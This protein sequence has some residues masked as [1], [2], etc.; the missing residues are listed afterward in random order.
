M[1]QRFMTAQ[2][3]HLLMVNFQVDP[4]LLQPL[5]PDGTELDFHDGRT[6]V[7]LVGFEFRDA[8][9]IGLSI[10]FHRNFD[11]INLRFY[12]RRS[13]P[14]GWRRGVVFVKEIV[15]V[16]AVATVARWVY[17]EN[18]VVRPVRHQLRLPAADCPGVIV[19]SFRQNRRWNSLSA[20]FGCELSHP[21]PESEEAFVAEHYWGYTRRGD[22]S[23]AEYH[24]TH[25]PWRIWLAK[26]IQFDFDFAET[27][28]LPFKSVFD[29]APTSAFVAD[30]SAVEVFSATKLNRQA[31]VDALGVRNT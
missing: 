27:Y 19:Y 23:T 6:F 15:R 14:T 20:N 29:S 12:V 31:T 2:W 7:S 26:N 21:L 4:D 1:P 22:G 3:R 25:P 10:P 17:N 11:E 24:V 30:G 5:V 8:R 28:G 9:L 13:T 18:F 16:W